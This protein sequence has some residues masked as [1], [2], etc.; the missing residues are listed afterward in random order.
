MEPVENSA[1][2]M[3]LKSKTMIMQSK[4]KSQGLNSWSQTIVKWNRSGERKQSTWGISR[5]W[6]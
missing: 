2:S 6:L 4:I 3:T 1:I 5:W